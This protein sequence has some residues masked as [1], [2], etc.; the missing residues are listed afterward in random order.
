MK[1]DHWLVPDWEPGLSIS[2]V[3]IQH[4]IEKDIKAI[5]LDVDKTLVYG[6]NLIIHKSVSNWI[7]EAKFYLHLHLLS[8]NPSKKRIKSVAD[9][10]N[11]PFTYGASKPRRKAVRRVLDQ[12]KIKPENISIIGDR[13]FTDVLV[14]NRLGLYT[15][16]VH[17]IGEDGCSASNKNLQ[18]IEKKFAE[19]LGAKSWN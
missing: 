2:N 12:I 14:G 6:K 3:P 5:I 16:L 4:F 19:F 13:I 8:N 1:S 11:I 10:F 15:V 9:Q 18:N 7:E 17:P